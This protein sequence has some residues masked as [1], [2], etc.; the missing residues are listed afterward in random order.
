MEPVQHTA[1]PEVEPP[2]S[3]LETDSLPG[4]LLGYER[5]AVVERF[6]R[7]RGRFEE[8]QRELARRDERI[9]DLEL[10]LLRWKKVR[11]LA[12]KTLIAAHRE[13]QTILAEAR[14]SAESMLKATREE[15]DRLCVDSE[16]EAT[17]KAN[18][19]LELAERERRNRL[20]EAG[21]ARAFVERT[22]EQ[23]A[24]FLV[25]ALNW[26]EE[27]G[28]SLEHDS[29]EHDDRSASE[30]QAKETASESDDRARQA[31]QH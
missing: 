5:H 10:E 24:D 2:S 15:A 28:L 31:L 30:S 9:E 26:Y 17:A 16:R 3:E 22:H 1:D 27:T 13:A 20:E 29:L 7:L 14:R 6:D 8:L 4:A 18:E 19:L 21:R 23:L 25:A 12:G 11:E